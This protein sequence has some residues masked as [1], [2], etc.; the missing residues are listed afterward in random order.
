MG[1]ELGTSGF[2]D[3]RSYQLGHRAPLIGRKRIYC[4]F[5]K[6][7]DARPVGNDGRY[8]LLWLSDEFGES[9]EFANKR[10]GGCYRGGDADYGGVG[11][12]F[13]LMWETRLAQMKQ[14]L[15]SMS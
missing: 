7:V 11:V 5:C 14:L 12:G 6:L 4:H 2:R 13:N 9:L 10:K 15:L 1:F 8:I 3:P